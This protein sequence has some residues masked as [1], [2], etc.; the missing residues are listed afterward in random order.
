MS[1]K[2][3]FM[4][5]PEF[6]LQTLKTLST[7]EFE[8]VCVYTQPPKKSDRGQK[9]NKTP[10]HTFSEKLNLEVRTPADLLSEDEYQYFKKLNPYI[11]IVVAYGKIIPKKYL[12]VPKKGFLNI[13]ASLLPKLRGAAPIQRSIMNSE[14]ETGISFMKIEEKLDAGPY[15]SQVKVKINSQTTTQSLSKELSLIASENIIKCLNLIKNEKANFISQNLDN[16]TYAKKIEKKESKI[17]WND[18]AQ[19]ILA[20]INSL[21]PD[22]GA[23]FEYDGVRYKIWTAKINERSG[24]PGAVIDEKLIIGCKDKSLEILEIQREGKNKL[25]T[26]IFLRGKKISIG[27]NIS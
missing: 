12:S 27:Q 22:P 21:N 13:H 4:G 24:S 25:S 2:I 23:W 1:K 15:M 3:V 20:K 19:N 16:V 8:I 5:T 9:I 18:T 7:S 11:A 6:S 17:I 14:K 10:I 26:N